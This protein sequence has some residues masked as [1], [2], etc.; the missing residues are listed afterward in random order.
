[1][2]DAGTVAGPQAMRMRALVRGALGTFG[3]RDFGNDG[4]LLFSVSCNTA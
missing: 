2:A 3:A 4:S 1:M